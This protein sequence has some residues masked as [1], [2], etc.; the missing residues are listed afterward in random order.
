MGY[1]IAFVCGHEIEVA[2]AEV[3]ECMELFQCSYDDALWHIGYCEYLAR[4]EA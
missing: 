1:V 3:I 4:K 2:D